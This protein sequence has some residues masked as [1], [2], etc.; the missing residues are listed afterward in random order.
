M[1]NV[2]L[3]RRKADEHISKWYGVTWEGFPRNEEQGI[4][5]RW[6][7]FT[8]DLT[9]KAHFWECNG[10]SRGCDLGAHKPWPLLLGLLP[11]C[12]ASATIRWAA[13]LHQGLLPWGFYLGPTCPWSET[14]V[15]ISSLVGISMSW[16]LSQLQKEWFTLAAY[17]LLAQ[18]I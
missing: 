10:G 14:S 11:L 18:N 16:I 15:T 5:L 17:L 6:L 3:V 9:S 8:V 4:W 2:S 13:L 12:S 1:A 7:I